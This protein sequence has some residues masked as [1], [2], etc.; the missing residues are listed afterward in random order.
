MKLLTAIIAILIVQSSQVMA[1]SMVVLCEGDRYYGKQTF[2]ISIEIALP[3]KLDRL[4]ILASENNAMSESGLSNLEI[5]GLDPVGVGNIQISENGKFTN[6][7]DRYE[8]VVTT[9]P[10]KGEDLTG[11]F[12]PNG[13]V[14]S[15]RARLWVEPKTYTLFDPWE[16]ELLRGVC[17]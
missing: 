3:E 15:F 14:S 9:L 7:S 10:G 13:R 12:R 1:G 2:K 4:I 11:F 5:I 6:K 16:N 17:L 8:F